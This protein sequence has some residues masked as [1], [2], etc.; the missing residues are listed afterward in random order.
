MTLP[1]NAWTPLRMVLTVCPRCFEEDPERDLDYE[2]DVL[3]GNLVAMDGRVYLRRHCRRGHGEVIGL[4]EEDGA[5]WE[6]PPAVADPHPRRSSP[7]GPPTPARSRWA[8][9]TAWATSRPST[10][11]SS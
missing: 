10:A 7:T 6:E 9:S 2:M 1:L 11:A 8:T 3:Q 4:Y 5:L